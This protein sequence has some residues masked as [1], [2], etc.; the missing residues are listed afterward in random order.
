[1]M[2]L[3]FLP[4]PAVFIFLLTAPLLAQPDDTR[5]HYTLD[6]SVVV[7]ANRYATPL[8]RQTN[9]M[10]V[11]SG[12]HVARYATHS[13]IELVQW[14]VPSAFLAQTRVG[15]FGVG[16]QGTGMLSLRGMG[17]KPNTGVSVMVDGH[18]DFMGIFG[19]PLP[20]VYGMDNIERVDVLLGP[21]STVFGGNALGGV[22]NIVT[23]P[24]DHNRVNVHLEGGSWGTYTAGLGMTRRFGDHGVR[25]SVRHNRSDGHVPQSN[26]TGTRVQADWDWRIDP[27]WQLSLR[28][29]Y[30]PSTFDDPTRVSDPVGLGTYGDIRRGMGQLVLKNTGTRLSGSTQAHVNLGHHEFFDGFVSDDRA[31]GLSTYQQWQGGERWSLAAGGDLLHYGGQANVND[32]EHTLSSVGAYALGMYS[33]L[34]FLHLRAGLRWQQHSLGRSIAVPTFGASVTPMQGLRLY[35]SMQS[36]YRHPTLQEL[37]LFPPSNPDLVEVRS[38]GY[39]AGAEFVMRRGSLRI[40]AFR[41]NA[42]DMITTVANPNPPPPVRFRNALEAEQWGLEAMLRY[43]ILPFLHTQLA[44]NMLEPDNLTAFNPAQQ[45]KYMVFA[46]MGAL[47]ATIAGQYVHDLYAG[48]NSTLPMPDYHLLD[49]ILSWRAPWAEMYVKA[50]NVLDR[51]Y[52]ILPGYA[53]PGAH[54]LFGIRYAIEH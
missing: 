45:F 46:D 40:A 19:H 9:A 5:P 21:A 1:M 24:I 29:R 35:A 31:L 12:E 8:S 49:L 11:I 41:T 2:F 33:P 42:V 14:E 34:S 44:W 13:A 3:S 6:D 20:D 4:R 25:L 52:M 7:V 37:Y 26:F 30:A 15:G 16:S 36:G 17:G 18:Q 54:L 43:R 53:A 32:T 48:D 28:S 50:R 23:R 27:V 22:V 10:N 38:T 51:Q 47:R 39:E